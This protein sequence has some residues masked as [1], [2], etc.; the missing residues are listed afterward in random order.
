M[1][2]Y[3]RPAIWFAA[4]TPAVLLTYRALTDDLGANPI[5]AITL[6]TGIWTLRL[7]V[8]TLAITPLRRLTGWNGIIR[9]RRLIGLFAFFY[10][11][12]HL[13]TYVV[14]DQ[15]FSWPDILADI[16]KRPYITVG[17]TAFVLL[18]PVAATSTAGMIRRLGGRRWQLLHRLVY[19]SASLG[20]LHYYWKVNVKGDVLRPIAYAAILAALLLFRV[21]WHYR[22]ALSGAWRARKAAA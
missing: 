4:L 19:A 22:P 6:E 20:V 14:L 18:V 7:L 17:F 10:A 8:A 2:S 15:F 21:W 16:G 3:I 9:Y 13:A 5:E 12:L 11:V 1:R